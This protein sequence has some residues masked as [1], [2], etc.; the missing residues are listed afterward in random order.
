MKV[1]AEGRKLIQSFEG[2]RVLAYLD[3][4][5][6]PT[7]GYGTTRYPPWHLEGRRVLMGD[8]CTPDMADL[9]M[10]WDLEG[11]ERAVDGLT[12]DGLNHCQ[13]DALCSLVYNIGQNAYRTSTIREWVNRDP[14]D[15]NIRGQFMRWVYDNG[16]IVPGLR[17]RRKAEADF[18]FAVPQQ[19]L[20]A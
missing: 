8:V 19:D 4:G 9:F 6:I 18:Y 20:A 15:P 14:N 16:A 5:G 12:T 3:T 11:T 7:I 10:S 17:N 13:F 2:L 1:T